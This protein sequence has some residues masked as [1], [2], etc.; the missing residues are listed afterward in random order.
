MSRDSALG[1]HPSHCFARCR[2]VG[3]GLPDSSLGLA[4]AADEE[5]AMRKGALLLLR[6]QRLLKGGVGCGRGGEAVVAVRD[7]ARRR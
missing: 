2:S 7:A 1:N 4:A 3:A 6:L 5:A